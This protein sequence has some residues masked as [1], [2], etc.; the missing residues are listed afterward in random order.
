MPGISAY[1]NGEW[2][3]A[4]ELHIPV[5]DFGFLLGATVTERL[6]TF[7]GEVFRLEEHLA[8]LR[9]SLEIIGLDSAA[10]TNE[11]A[12][13]IGEFIRRNQPLIDRE[14]DWSIIAFATPGTVGR[15]HSTVCVH[16]YPLPFRTWAAYYETGLP[17]VVSSIRQVPTNCWPAELKCRSRMH[18]YLAD[19]EADAKRRG[20]RAIVLDQDGYVAEGTT[21][22][23]IIY[24]DRE[25]LLSPPLEHILLGVSLGVVQDLATKLKL[26]FS[27]RPLTVEDLRTADEAMFASTSICVLPVVECDG[28]LIGDG[29][30]GPNYR[31]ILSA[32][33]DLVGVDVAQQARRFADRSA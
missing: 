32:W 18:Y 13:V 9:R 1:F 26:P 25:G 8:R 23:V 24:R 19:R 28:R 21:A 7:R 14:D 3:P 6:R 31:Q 22:N 5:D 12:D 30:P 15:R 33:S 17:V 11:I 20:A 10:I 27:M 16:G 29:K 2:I 4:T